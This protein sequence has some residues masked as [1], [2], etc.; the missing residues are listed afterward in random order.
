MDRLFHCLLTLVCVKTSEMLQAGIEI[1]ENL[2]Q[3][4]I[5]LQSYRHPQRKWRNFLRITFSYH[6]SATLSV[7]FLGRAITHTH[8]HIYIYI[9]IY[10]LAQYPSYMIVYQCI[11]LLYNVNPCDSCG[12]TII[13][14]K[15][16]CD[17]RRKSNIKLE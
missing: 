8:T 4:D 11:I 14:T 3:S 13:P 6:L 7:Q 1:Q 5:L 9:Y 10:I 15:S 17:L 2:R 16:I 12:D